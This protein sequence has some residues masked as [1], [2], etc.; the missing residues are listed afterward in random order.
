MIETQIFLEA[1]RERGIGMYSGVPCS[2]LTPLINAVIGSPHS[3]YVGASNEGDAVAIA[4]GAELAGKRAAVLFQNSGLGNAVSPL[5]S[6]TA[7]FQIPVLVLATWRGQPGG[8]ADEPQHE[9]MGEI[10]PALF[11]LMKIPYRILPDE[12]AGCLAAVDTACE[13]MR[14]KRLPFALIIRKGTF[15]ACELPQQTERSHVSVARQEPKPTPTVFDPD[16]VLRA[17]RSAVSPRDAVVAT[18][19]FTGRALYAQGDT[20]NQ[21]YMVGSMGCA[22]SLAL[23]LALAQP[24]RRVVVLDGDGAFLMRMGALSSIGYERPKNLVHVLLD[25]GVHDSTGAQATVAPAIDPVQIALGCGYPRCAQVAQLDELRAHLQ[26]TDREL[27][28]LHI[29]TQPREDRKLP[30]PTMTP[31]E[32]ATRFR[33]CLGEK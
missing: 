33:N 13:S 32:V 12:E 6:L 16:E 5:T 21:F 29:K 31:V 14:T 20:A 30:R 3:R 22:S 18:T 9:L 25:N 28:F 19:G 15:A 1:L 10:T 24:T 27:T 11:E 17:I 26:T 2:Y 8:A 7:T 4:C 23:G